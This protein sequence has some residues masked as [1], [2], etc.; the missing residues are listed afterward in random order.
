MTSDA[1]AWLIPS[2]VIGIG[3]IVAMFKWPKIWLGVVIVSMP[4]FLSDTGKGL[5][6]SEA[7][8]GGFILGSVCTWMVYTLASG[9]TKI[10]WL[11]DRL[12]ILFLVLSVT[13]IVVAVLNEVDPFDW[14]L[15]WI[16]FILILLYFPL[17]EY[18]G[19]SE[20]DLKHL[21]LLLAIAVVFMAAYTAYE[22]KNRSSEGLMYAYQL[23][24][25]RSRLFAPAFS[26]SLVLS[27][28]LVFHVKK[29]SGRIFV[30]LFALLSGAALLQS[31]TRSLWLASA[32]C[33]LLLMFFLKWRHNA[34]LITSVVLIALSTY[35]VAE[36][37]YPR[38]TKIAVSIIERRFTSST[39]LTGGDYSFET[40][41][42]EAREASRWI[43]EYPL[44]GSGLRADLLS[45]GPI[46]QFHWKKPFIH[47]GYV[48]LLFKFGIPISL[49][50]F[51]Y[52]FTF[53]ARTIRTSIR[54]RSKWK[55]PPLAK[56]VAIGTACFLPSLYVSIMVAGF[57]DQRYGNV[58]LAVLF[59]LI[60][61]SHGLLQKHDA[62]AQH[63]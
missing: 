5:S 18:F 50:V 12:I 13:N 30:F 49:V 53:S 17:K 61:I 39:Q 63:S 8:L 40:R 23:I 41:L 60:S 24:A 48:S 35:V 16:V 59:A 28:A 55:A 34:A 26:M 54:F 51:A 6:A 46:E 21:L 11:G 31:M 47:I 19:R 2:V 56:A 52:L 7:I 10:T 15:E 36:T 57:V 38:L 44:S 42:I 43:K 20:R 14:L 1:L 58:I 33:M 45:W 4:W 9:R 29:W 32:F 27:V 25:S 62:A 22:F 3:L 37:L